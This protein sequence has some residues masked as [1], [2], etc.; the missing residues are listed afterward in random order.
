MNTSTTRHLSTSALAKLL[1]KESKEIF[2]L[3][4]AG[5]WIIKTDNQWQ[6]TEK[7]KF[8]GGIYVTHPKYGTYI[9]WPESVREHPLLAF[10]PEAT[11]TA[12]Q[13][14]HQL[15]ISARLVNALLAEQG[16][17]VRYVR[18]WRITPQGKVIGG[19]ELISEPS[20]IPY[21]V[22]P[23]TLLQEVTFLKNVQQLTAETLTVNTSLDG[24][25]VHSLQQLRVYNWLYLSGIRFATN[26]PLRLIGDLQQADI[27]LPETRLYLELWSAEA[28]ANRLAQLLARQA[29][30]EQQHIIFCD[31]HE[32]ELEAIENKLTR[33]LLDAGVA[34]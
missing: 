17:I 22:W 27:F 25:P 29:W 3:L 13:L 15:G 6:L 34:V 24:R 20:G 16:F 14:G 4:R 19:S 33:V 32:H 1:D 18:G 2:V 31:L 30:Y 8:E 23:E 9:A 10:L 28:D 12:T 11:L 5:G 26:Y 21:V 7:G